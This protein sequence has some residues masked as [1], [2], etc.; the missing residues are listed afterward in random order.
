VAAKIELGIKSRSAHLRRLSVAFA[1]ELRL[2]IIA[3]LYMREMSAKQFHE[4]FGGGSIARITR[5]FEKLAEHGWLEYVRSEGPGG[6]RRGGVEHFYRATEP[7]FCDQ[8]TWALLPYS[9]RVAFS[10]NTFK[11]IAA[12]LREAIQAGAFD[13]ADNLTFIT[14]RL[15]Q[16]GWQR[17]IEAISVQFMGLFEEQAEAGLRISRSGEQPIRASVVQIAFESPLPGSGPVAPLL[18]EDRDPLVP[19]PERISKVFADEI[20]MQIIEE[21]NRRQMSVSLFHAEFGGDSVG[22]IRRRFGKLAEVGWLV[23]VDTKTGGRRRGATEKFYRAAG[24]A[25]FDSHR[26]PWADVP[27]SL[28]RT[29]GWR[30][31]EALSALVKEAMKLGTFDLRDDSCLAWSLLQLDGQSWEKVTAGLDARLDFAREEEDRARVRMK[32][33][34]EQP[35]AMTIAL[36]AFESPKEAE[37]E[38]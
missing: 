5:N 30:D 13:P 23:Q 6:K 2:K 16:L 17:V 26:G 27:D 31:F 1:I 28:R 15:D 10:W 11:E 38:L 36:G 7:A 22:G 35:V 33:S 20:C 29:D 19:F 21:A 3:E 18:V 12:R 9:I 25:I 24:P 34:G 8:E 37:K 4:E 14:L 32:R